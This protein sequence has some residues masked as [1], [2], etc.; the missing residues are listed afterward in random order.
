M[1]SCDFVEGVLEVTCSAAVLC[2]PFEGV[3]ASCH[4]FFFS[5]LVLVRCANPGQHTHTGFDFASPVPH[6]KILWCGEA[7]WVETPPVG[8]VK[9][10]IW[11][12]SPYCNTRRSPAPIVM[13]EWRVGVVVYENDRNLLLCTHGVRFCFDVLCG[14]SPVPRVPPTCAPPCFLARI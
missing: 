6:R 3:P 8:R 9:P 10:G 14:P 12:V 1:I 4:L 11:L 13:V 2:G 7:T 5:F